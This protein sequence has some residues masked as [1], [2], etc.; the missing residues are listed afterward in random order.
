MNPQPENQPT[1]G[2]FHSVEENCRDKSAYLLE[3][4]R[5]TEADEQLRVTRLER[6][7]YLAGL[8]RIL[9]EVERIEGTIHTTYAVTSECERLRDICSR[10]AEVLR[11]LASCAIRFTTDVQE[12]M[13]VVHLCE[14]VGFLPGTALKVRSLVGLPRFKIFAEEPCTVTITVLDF[15]ESV[16]WKSTPIPINRERATDGE[17][18]AEIPLCLFTDVSEVCLGIVFDSHLVAKSVFLDRHLLASSSQ[19]QLYHNEIPIEKCFISFDE[20][21]SPPLQENI[22][23][24]LKIVVLSMSDIML[25]EGLERNLTLAL[26]P[27][28]VGSDRRLDIELNPESSCIEAELEIDPRIS[29]Q[30]KVAVRSSSFTVCTGRFTLNPHQTVEGEIKVN[31]ELFDSE[32]NP[33]GHV[34]FGVELLRATSATVA[35]R[36]G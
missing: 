10:Q 8:N 28:T 32:G 17:C 16:L 18:V 5:R 1:T 12:R 30:A 29:F 26:I 34:E 4:F 3:R 33:N 31:V 2:S 35:A 9:S 13:R 11:E 14:S 20:P 36:S 15:G 23:A 7:K 22:T 27:D 24:T 19:L 21:N 6:D 25:D